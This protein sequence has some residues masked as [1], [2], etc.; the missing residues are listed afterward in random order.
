M[1]ISETKLK[2]CQLLR[3]TTR[4]LKDLVRDVTFWRD[5]KGDSG[6][7]ELPLFDGQYISSY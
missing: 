4:L 6:L 5:P 7:S 2:S 3:C 1:A